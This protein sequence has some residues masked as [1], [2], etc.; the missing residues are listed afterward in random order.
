MFY[1]T[2][3]LLLSEQGLLRVRISLHQR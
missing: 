1:Y 2:L 3:C